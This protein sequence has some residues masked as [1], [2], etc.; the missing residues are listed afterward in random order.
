MPSH[1][2]IDRNYRPFSP[3]EIRKYCEHCKRWHEIN[4]N[5]QPKDKC[6]KCGVMI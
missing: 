6:P 4:I 3:R 5:Y 2:E 1:G